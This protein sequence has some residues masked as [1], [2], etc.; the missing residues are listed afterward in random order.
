MTIFA[1]PVFEATVFVDDHE[2]FKGKG[3]AG[4]WAEQLA[5]EL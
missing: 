4:L 2:L 3:A 5:V 1:Q